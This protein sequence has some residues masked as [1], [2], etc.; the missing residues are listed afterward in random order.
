MW[1]VIPINSFF[2]T[3]TRL[4]KILDQNKRI[5]LTK[6]MADQMINCLTNTVRNFGTENEIVIVGDFNQNL[7]FY[8]HGRMG[9]DKS[10]CSNDMF[11]S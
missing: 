4:S 11:T 9:H 8:V 7:E 6:M 3:M 5:E 1:A 10:S 2:K